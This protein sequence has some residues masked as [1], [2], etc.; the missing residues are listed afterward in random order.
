MWSWN[1]IMR[2]Q[3]TTNQPILSSKIGNPHFCFEVLFKAL[4]D[5]RRSDGPN[6]RRAHQAG[7]RETCRRAWD[8]VPV[9]RVLDR[10]LADPFSEK[11]IGYYE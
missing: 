10:E 8:P 1:G 2:L 6:R 5:H 4:R 11:Q 7:G 3:M 9:H